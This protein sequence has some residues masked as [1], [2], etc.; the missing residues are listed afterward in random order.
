MA[1][2]EEPLALA[3]EDQQMPSEIAIATAAQCWCDPR[4]E[5]REMDVELATVFAERVDAWI[6]T[7]RQHANNEE[8]YRGLLDRIGER[9]GPSAYVSDDGS[10]QDSVLRAKVPELVSALLDELEAAR[11]HE[12]G[13][14]EEVAMLRR[15]LGQRNAD[16]AAARD[17]MTLTQARAMAGTT[18]WASHSREQV[19][20]ALAI[21]TRALDGAEAERDAYLHGWVKI[22]AWASGLQSLAA[23]RWILNAIDGALAPAKEGA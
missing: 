21:V 6:E 15:E 17:A 13:Y 2:S 1:A 3:K 4:T 12:T 23:R 8:Y 19:D 20:A 7:A 10:V 14:E 18:T 16:L 22:R 9:V 5:T 11:R